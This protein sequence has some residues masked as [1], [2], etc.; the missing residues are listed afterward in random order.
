MSIFKLFIK[1]LIDERYVYYRTNN[2]AGLNE[3]YESTTK[4]RL[5]LLA[6]L[7]TDSNKWTDSIVWIGN[8]L[9]D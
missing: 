6:S 2:K 1:I 4:G 8:K 7:G 3:T 5:Y 9:F